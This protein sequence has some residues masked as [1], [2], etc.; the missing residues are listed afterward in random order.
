M[1]SNSRAARRRA[2]RTSP[3]IP[4]PGLTRT[5]YDYAIEPVVLD[6]GDISIVLG[7]GDADC[8]P[9]FALAIGCVEPLDEIIELLTKY[10]SCLDCAHEEH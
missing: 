9:S 6:N 4:P 3:D 2:G 10:R 8:A 5:Y 1:A 7:I